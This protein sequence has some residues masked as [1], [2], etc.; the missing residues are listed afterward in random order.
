MA[1]QHEESEAE[2]ADFDQIG[3]EEHPPLCY[4]GHENCYDRHEFERRMDEADWEQERKE[5]I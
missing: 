4:L 1:G 5:G 2:Y 3:K